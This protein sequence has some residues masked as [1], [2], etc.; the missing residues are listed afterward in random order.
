M[1]E[2]RERIFRLPREGC[3][4]M[5]G[6]FRLVRRR[7]SEETY[8]C[9]DDHSSQEQL[10]LCMDHAKSP[11]PDK[12]EKGG[13]D[14]CFVIKDA[15]GVF[16]GVGAWG[17]KGIDSSLHARELAKLTALYVVSHGAGAI[18]D[19]LRHADRESKQIGTSTACVASL[20][21][22]CLEGVNVGDSGLIVVRGKQIVF[23]TNRQQH[24]FNTPYQLGTNSD[25][26]VSDGQFFRFDLRRGDII[27]AA[28]DGLWDNME[29]KDIAS[30]A[31]RKINQR[32]RAL[33]ID[34]LQET[35]EF[36]VSRAKWLARKPKGTSPFAREARRAG[37]MHEGGK[38]DDVT[39]IIVLV[40]R[41]NPQS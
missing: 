30:Y 2:S 23:E 25:D 28:S 9:R 17:K 24:S 3:R 14:S 32:G 8:Y 41:K 20:Y 29:R 6:I 13:E 12:V 39:V 37:K 21:R 35:A 27:V 26:R 18:E 11:H 31:S 4:R 5:A 19:G 36:L 1:T 15:F 16:D 34:Q 40:R 38:M 22:G 33:V 7:K 10:Q